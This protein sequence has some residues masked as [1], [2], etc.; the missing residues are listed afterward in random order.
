MQLDGETWNKIFTSLKNICKETKLKEFQFKLIHRIVVTKKELNR[1]GM[2]MDEE[3]LYC[4]EHDSIDHTFI[5]CEFV[6]SFVKK[7]TTGLMLSVTRT[8][9]LQLKKKHLASCLVHRIKH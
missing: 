3:C 4:V 8:F 1:Y 5:E 9:P 2:K 7:S 6:K